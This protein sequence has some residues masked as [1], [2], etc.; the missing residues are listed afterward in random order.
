MGQT[1]FNMRWYILLL[2]LLL[3]DVCQIS[4]VAAAKDVDEDDSDS[5]GT[6]DD[7]DTDDDGIPDDEDTDDDNDGVPDEKDP[8]DDNDG[9]LDDDEYELQC[10]SNRVNQIFI[11]KF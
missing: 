1:S 5:D 3:V 10:I 7:A 9:V 8:D 2:A 4:D 11:G 6:P